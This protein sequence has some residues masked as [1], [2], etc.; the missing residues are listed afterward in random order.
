MTTK[1]PADRMKEIVD[2]HRLE[3]LAE[4]SMKRQDLYSALQS[5]QQVLSLKI[6]LKNKVGQARTLNSIGKLCYEM[7]DYQSG[8]QY[9]RELIGLLEKLS[10]DRIK[11]NFYRDLIDFYGGLGDIEAVNTLKQCL[12]GIK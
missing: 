9:H 11:K 3:L 5:Y 6:K 7:G 2:I 1:A 8:R 10:S 4:N 12:R